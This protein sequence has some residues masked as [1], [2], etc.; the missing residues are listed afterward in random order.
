MKALVLRKPRTMEL[1]DVPVPALTDDRHVLVEVKVCGICGSDV[2]YWAGENPWALHTLGRHMDNP[3]NMILGHEFS[4]VVVAARSSEFEHLV[5]RRV[6][7]QAFRTCGAVQ[8]WTREPVPEYCPHWTRAG[9][10]RDGL[11][12]RRLCRVLS[13]L[14]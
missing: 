5:G 7:V 8:Y 4:G 1:L 12:S 3:P 11:L 14:G 10:G 9:M 13:G 6:G 2:R